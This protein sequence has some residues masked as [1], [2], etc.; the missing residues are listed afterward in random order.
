MKG[1]FCNGY[2]KER[3]ESFIQK[4]KSAVLFFVFE[5]KTSVLSTAGVGRWGSHP[6]EAS[7]ADSRGLGR[8]VAVKGLRGV[9]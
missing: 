3:G 8:G 6:G 5:R 4:P 1:F 2:C 9:I 7:T